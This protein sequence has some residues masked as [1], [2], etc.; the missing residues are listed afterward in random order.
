MAPTTAPFPA[1]FFS[2]LYR[3]CGRVR[4]HDRLRALSPPALRCAPWR[5]RS[6]TTGAAALLLAGCA[7]TGD[8]GVDA[9]RSDAQTDPAAAATVAGAVEAPPP[10]PVPERP[11][12]DES[13]YPLLV[14]EF[15]LRRR[16]FDTALETYLEQAEI[17][18]DPQVSAHATHLAQF[19]Q[20][21]REA[22]RAVRLWVELDPDNVEANSTLAILL[23]RQGRTR[24]ALPH[25][26]V[27]ARSGEAARFPLLLNGF[28]TKPPGEQAALDYAVNSLLQDDLGDN[29]SLLLTHAL[30]AEE[31]GR[32]DDAE[33]RLA[34]VFAR[35][36]YQQQALVLEAKLLL[37]RD[38]PQP[39]T[40][41]EAALEADATRNDLR[42]QYA[43]LLAGRDMAAAREQFEILSA[44]APHDANLLFS[45]ALL[46]HELDDNDAARAYLGQVLALGQR[47]DEVYLFLGQIASSEG[48]NDQAIQYL[49]QVG[50][51]EDLLRATLSIAKLQ[52]AAGREDELASYMDRLRESYP[53]R[54]E[55]LFALEANIYS[56]ANK[57]QRGIALL[58]RAIGEYPESDN[59]R[60]AR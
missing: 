36:P 17:L 43:R 30:M 6:A 21:E 57:D 25:F 29:V 46:N 22:F 24:E 4:A 23:A 2:R 1:V 7:T 54:R 20:R 13:V 42:L 28:K 51:G 44:S 58:S 55:Q 16:D 18:R 12:P 50:D 38:D 31:A 19:M 34:P 9:A 15:A 10:P 48:D 47:E 8:P 59:L 3:A 52:L 37:A 35:E 45:L 56:E 60:Y 33:A 27:V 32:L 26:T 5:Y 40:R 39:F 49:Q 41:I 11:I 53:P 14:A